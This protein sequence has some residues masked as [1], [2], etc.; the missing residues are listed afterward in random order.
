[1][2]MVSGN[3]GETNGRGGT[4]LSN[5]AE[6][7]PVHLTTLPGIGILMSSTVPGIFVG[8]WPQSWDTARYPT[9]SIPGTVLRLGPFHICP[10]RGESPWPTPSSGLNAILSAV[11]LSLT[12]ASRPAAHFST[13][14]PGVSMRSTR[15]PG[16]KNGSLPTTATSFLPIRRPRSLDSLRAPSEVAWSNFR[17]T[18]SF[19]KLSGGGE[20]RVGTTGQAGSPCLL[21]GGS[22]LM[23]HNR[24][25]QKVESTQGAWR[26]VDV[27]HNLKSIPRV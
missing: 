11:R 27:L 2:R 17:I 18:A 19:S 13:S 12:L 25:L 22:G 21:T 24:R 8:Y 5:A 20:Q 6:S 16:E 26:R 7:A 1:M 10:G 14:L 3:S 4:S 9:L 15:H 23:V